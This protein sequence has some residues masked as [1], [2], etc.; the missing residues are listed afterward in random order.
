MEKK[1]SKIPEKGNIVVKFG[2]DWCAPCKALKPIIEELKEDFKDL[3][4]IIELDV[5]EHQALA[6]SYGVRGIP[7]TFFIKDGVVQGQLTGL[8]PKESFSERINLMVE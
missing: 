7:A 5:D 3:A 1:M 4:E 2:A 6:G 8:H